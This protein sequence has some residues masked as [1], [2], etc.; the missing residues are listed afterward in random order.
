TGLEEKNVSTA[1][2][3]GRLLSAAMKRDE[4]RQ[5]VLQSQYSFRILNNAKTR[6]IHNTDI[7][8][9]SFLNQKEYGYE[10]IG[11]KTGYLPEAG[12]CL[13]TEIKKDGREVIVVVLN[14]STIADRFQDV[15]VIAD[16]VFSNYEWE[17]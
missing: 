9:D 10:L 8:V 6:Q 1:F 11:G 2:D 4:I 5:T 16:W 14:S 13:A 12:Y 3:L 17:R 7:L 15:K